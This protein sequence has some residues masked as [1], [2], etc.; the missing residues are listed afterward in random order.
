MG[1][2]GAPAQLN[3]DRGVEVFGVGKRMG[4]VGGLYG[5]AGWTGARAGRCGR[6]VGCT[7]WCLEQPGCG[8]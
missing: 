5:L 7:L 2:V 8:R 1:E 3:L 4:E 6:P